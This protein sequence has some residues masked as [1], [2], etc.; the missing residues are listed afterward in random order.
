MGDE[1]HVG[2]DLDPCQLW[3]ALQRL[4]HVRQGAYWYPLSEHPRPEGLRIVGIG[5]LDVTATEGRL[6]AFLNSRATRFI[7]ELREDGSSC[8]MVTDDL[9][10]E[11][12]GEEVYYTPEDMSWIIYVSHEG[13]LTFGGSTLLEFLS[14]ADL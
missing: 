6:I 8:T 13:T 14:D 7:R 1:Q 3:A 12:A 9:S 4:W 11:Y 2:A 10:L 5:G